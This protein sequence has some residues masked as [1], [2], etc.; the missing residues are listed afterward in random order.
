[1]QGALAVVAMRDPQMDGLSPFGIPFW[2][3]SS[4][5]VLCIVVNS[6]FGRDELE[7]D[8]EKIRHVRRALVGFVAA[9]LI[10]SPKCGA[11]STNRTVDSDSGST[12]TGLEIRDFPPASR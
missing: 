5:C 12:Q 8:S 6:F 1:M 9:Q 11:G 4:L 2:A 7:I 10:Q 3:S